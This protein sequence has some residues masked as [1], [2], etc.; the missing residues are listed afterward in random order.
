VANGRYKKCGIVCADVKCR[1]IP[2]RSEIRELKAQ[3]M[4]EARCYACQ[5]KVLVRGEGAERRG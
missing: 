2:T 1:Y 4:A 3:G 5:G